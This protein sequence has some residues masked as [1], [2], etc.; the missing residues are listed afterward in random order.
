VPE[1]APFAALVYDDAVAGAIDLLTAP[2]YD[3]I[4]EPRRRAYL[5]GSPHSIVHVD[6]AEGRDDPSMPGNRYEH[7]ASLLHRWRTEGVLRALPPAYYAYEMTWTDHEGVPRRVRGLLCAMTLEPWGGAILPHEHVMPG[8]VRDRLRLLRATRTHLSPV[9][10]TVAGPHPPLASALDEATSAEPL[11]AVTDREAVTHRLWRVDPDLPFHRWLADDHLLIADGH[12]RYT[13]AL[14]YR[15]ERR[16]ASG[17]GPW[18]R[19]LTFVVDAGAEHLHVLPYHRIQMAG[20]VPEPDLLLDGA[21]DLHDHLDD[22]SGR[23]G[24]LIADDPPAQAVLRVDA[25]M[26]P[27]VV[28]LHH[29]W[30]DDQVP[31]EELRFTHEVD[32][33]LEAVRRGEARAAYLLPPTTPERILEVVERGERL[34]RKSTFFWPKPRTGMVLM[35]LDDGA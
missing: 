24:I 27:A 28:G 26:G 23:V 12:H 21:D 5:H 33:A 15:D 14:A 10:G 1:V 17:P 11:F 22:A 34:P 20:R 19:L 9:Y 4:D 7:A 35:P 29:A 31:E 6:L 25:A 30:L 13:T 3:V 2:P 18:D 16:A 8:P 32:E